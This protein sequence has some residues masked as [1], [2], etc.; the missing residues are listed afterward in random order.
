M[1]RDRNGPD[2]RG[3]EDHMNAKGTPETIT[4]YLKFG[5]EIEVTA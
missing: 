5:V 2:G 4:T 1:L 3:H